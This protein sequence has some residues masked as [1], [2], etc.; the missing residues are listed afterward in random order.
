M[1]RRPGALRGGYVPEGGKLV[2]LLAYYRG[3]WRT[4]ATTRTEAAGRW[5]YRYRVGAT[6]GL[7]V[8]VS[9]R[10]WSGVA[11]TGSSRS[12]TD[13]PLAHFR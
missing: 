1:L 6:R 13:S 7:V 8:R 9:V 10:G 5:S 3:Q 12:R 2:D 11:T 4:F